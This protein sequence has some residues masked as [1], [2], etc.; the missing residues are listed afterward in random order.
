ML[1]CQIDI[2]ANI[3]EEE[4]KVV[5]PLP[6]KS[7][8]PF[9]KKWKVFEG[10]KQ[11]V[12][13]LSKVHEEEHIDTLSQDVPNSRDDVGKASYYVQELQD[14][15]VSEYEVMPKKWVQLE[16]D[17]RSV[18]TWWDKRITEIHS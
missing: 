14:R 15:A 9:A 13:V 5:V 16:V 4:I 10:A 18:G 1:L 12:L 11:L 8:A 6:K 3:A 17:V 7:G 2:F